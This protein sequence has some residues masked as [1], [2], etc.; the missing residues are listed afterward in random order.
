MLL[1]LMQQNLTP[2]ADSLLAQAREYLQG[3]NED[4]FATILAHMACEIETES[5]L[6]RLI[7][8]RGGDPVLGDLLWKTVRRIPMHLEADGVYRIYSNLSNDYPKGHKD[9][10]VPAADWWQ[11]WKDSREVRNAIVHGKASALAGQA[12]TAIDVSAAY[13]K[14]VREKTDQAV[15]RA[16]AQAGMRSITGPTYP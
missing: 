7:Q 5:S 2:Y 1:T 16:Q 15:K 6:T 3:K 4:N 13:V 14:H 9:L 12:A 11:K 10:Q 8:S